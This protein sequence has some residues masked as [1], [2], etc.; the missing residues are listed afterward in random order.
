MLRFQSPVAVSRGLC[1]YDAGTNTFTFRGTDN[2]LI[3]NVTTHKLE[4]SADVTLEASGFNDLYLNSVGQDIFANAGRYINMTADTRATITATTEDVRLYAEDGYVRVWGDQN[5]GFEVREDDGLSSYV[6]LLTTDVGGNDYGTLNFYGNTAE[7]L[8]LFHDND[9]MIPH[10]GFSCDGIGDGWGFHWIS[11]DWIT[12]PSHGDNEA[13]MD[14]AGAP[15]GSM[16]YNSATNQ[17]MLKRAG[18]WVKIDFT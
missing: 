15:D 1:F 5:K 2:V 6:S 14:A 7:R 10:A 8:T 9:T 12:L 3:D 17:L 16:Y 4:L 11:F 18:G 13:A